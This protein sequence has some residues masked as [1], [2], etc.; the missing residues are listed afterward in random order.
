MEIS[1]K[2]YH[3]FLLKALLVVGL[4]WGG[5][6]LTLIGFFYAS[7]VV[8]GAL[9]GG[10][11]ILHEGSKNGF[12]FL[13]SREIS[14][15]SI[16]FLIVTIVFLFF[17]TPTVFTGRDQGSFSEAAIRL[18]QN[19]KLKFS[20]PTSEE[21]FKLHEPGRAL[22]FPGFYYTLDG[23]LITQFSL[24]YITWL[25][26][27]FSLFGLTGFAVANGVLFFTFLL[28]FY[29]L[30][31]LSLKAS[32]TIPMMLFAITSFV[33]MWFSRFTLSE[34]MA[35]MLVWLAILS[36][37]LF[38]KNQKALPFTIFL[39]TIGL[40]CFTRIE[41]FA[42]LVVSIIILALNED[43]R[44]YIKNR[45]FVR[46]FLPAFLLFVIFIA[47]GYW[48]IYFYKEIAKALF[49]SVSTPKAT[50]L[51]QLK[52]SA[53][54]EF[55]NLKMFYLYGMAGFFLTGTL[56]AAISFWKKEFHKL[57]PLFFVAPTFIYL[58]DSQIS[59]DQ[60]W[61]LRRFMFSILPVAIYY[62][63]LF[64][65][66][67]LEE[68]STDRKHYRSKALSVG[69]VTVLI[70]MNLPAFSKYL[71]F[72]ENKNLLTQVKTLSEKFSSNDL[73]LVDQKASGDGWS[74]IA[75][76]MSSLHGK[77]AV[78]FFNNQDLTKL[79]T[80]KFKNVYLIAPDQQVPL[81]LASTIGEKLTQVSTYEFTTSKLDVEPANPMKK[82]CMP[83]KI[84][85]KIT[86][87]IFRV[88]K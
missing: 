66:H 52:N 12:C 15:A 14:I 18:S 61:M 77:N 73:I 20:T 9:L 22:N 45:T 30:G 13:P 75:G 16:I 78:Y 24:V 74:M 70:I 51:G 54:P 57:I 36:L 31:R 28:S 62:S 64:L 47:N 88:S 11:W 80:S 68:R 67:L 86:G 8:V 53:L 50:Y 19:H 1:G 21:F 33:L 65:G 40:L 38:L 39:M 4:A 49:P 34:N 42:F 43:A 87:K 5:F 58:Y 44:E 71:T 10:I 2:D 41:G 76:P 83:E 79:D 60:P 37:M 3:I 7:I 82:L 84:E 63:G 35:L 81:Y 29:M 46:F 26:I 17:S 27:F 72:S 25:A 85:V 6:L 23:K 55:Y 59:P 32:T 48:D 56:G 69:V